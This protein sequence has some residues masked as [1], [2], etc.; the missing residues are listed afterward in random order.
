MKEEA[1]ASSFF[2]TDVVLD[3]KILALVKV[4]LK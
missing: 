2:A 1:T 3:E 4:I